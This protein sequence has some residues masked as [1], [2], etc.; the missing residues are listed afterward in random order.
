VTQHGWGGTVTEILIVRF[1]TRSTTRSD[2]Y[3]NYGLYGE[4]DGPQRLDYHLWAIRGSD[5]LVVVDTG[6]SRSE[7]DRRGRETLVDPV[8]ALARCGIAVED[9]RTVVLTHLHYDH[10][11][12]VHRFPR[13]RIVVAD[14][15]LA[16][17]T[18][19]LADRQ[20]I[21]Y[22]RDPAALTALAA[23]DAQGRV[24]RFTDRTT[25]ADG[26]EVVEVGGH[27]PGQSVVRVTGSV[28]TVVLASDAAHFREELDRD[29]PFMSVTD[30]PDTYRGLDLLRAWQAAGDEIVT[31]HDPSELSR[32]AAV[33]GLEDV[34]ARIALDRETVDQGRP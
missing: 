34:A 11:G 16:F 15:E 19:S 31:G 14:R 25:I 4:D 5:G 7:G 12:N 6:F 3:L 8:V 23:A 28:R 20:Q 26:V 2:S 13:A 9:V 24:E 33:P 27:T 1:G 18:S 21:A 32:A 30:L 17:W 10:V 22:F 29:M